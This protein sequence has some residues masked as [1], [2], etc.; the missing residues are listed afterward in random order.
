MYTLLTLNF[1]ASFISA[2][3]GVFSCT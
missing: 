2:Q 1:G 3:K